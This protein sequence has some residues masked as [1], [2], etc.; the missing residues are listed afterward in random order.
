MSLF[1]AAGP[2]ADQTLALLVAN[3]THFAVVALDEVV[4]FLLQVRCQWQS[5]SPVI[6]QWC[7]GTSR[8]TKPKLRHS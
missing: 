1:G 8:E 3:Q 6:V 2:G 4:Q 5:K 7:G